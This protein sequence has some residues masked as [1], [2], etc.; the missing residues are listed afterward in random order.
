MISVQKHRDLNFKNSMM[1]Y[2]QE[3]EAVPFSVLSP[4]IM[5]ALHVCFTAP[6]STVSQRQ[7]VFGIGNSCAVISCSV[8]ST[9]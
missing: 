4:F 1:L 7:A 9:T 5:Q 8:A 2:L 6:S 3:Q